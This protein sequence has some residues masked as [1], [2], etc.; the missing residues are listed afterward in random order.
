MIRAIIFDLNGVFIQSP[1]LSERF[2]TDFG[3][4]TDQFLLALKEI[5]AIVRQQNAGDAFSY[6]QPYLKKWNVN[7]NRGQFFNYW[8]SA[9]KEVPELIKYAKELQGKG[10]KIIILSN[11]FVERASYYDTNFP[12]LKSFDGLYYSWQT[13][14]VKPDKR[15]FE[16]ILKEH[17][18]KPQECIYFDDS[19]G[20]IEV[21][22]SL[23]IKAFIYKGLEDIQKIINK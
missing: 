20:N 1:K 7:L 9:E 4:P 13:G 11:N 5:M 14:F 10:I 12:F 21:A 17:H 16:K 6:W 23:G 2:K 18:L 19:E 22:Q 3:V 15:A 8:F